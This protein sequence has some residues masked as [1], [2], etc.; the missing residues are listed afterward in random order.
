MPYGED[1]HPEAALVAARVECNQLRAE[2]E[3]LKAEN[4]RLK[5]IRR[6]MERGDPCYEEPKP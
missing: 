6:S 2:I 5:A 4:A 1:P 3:R